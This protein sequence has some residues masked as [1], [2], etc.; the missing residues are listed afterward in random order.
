MA[1]RGRKPRTL[2]TKQ[3]EVEIIDAYAAKTST[4][5]ELAEM[6]GIH[7]SQ[8]YRLLKKY[9]VPVHQ[10]PERPDKNGK[11]VIRRLPPQ[12][13]EVPQVPE[14]TEVPVMHPTEMAVVV[15]NRNLVQTAKTVR[16]PESTWEV[17]YTGTLMVEADDVEE[18][19]REA[20]KLGMVKR[21]YSVRIKGQ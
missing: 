4:A 12:E 2:L 1:T 18:A 16:R 15:D 20:R 9:M 10:R 3:Q 19:I 14:E 5:K 8:F 17:K 7:D 13:I 21:I 6:Y 11:V